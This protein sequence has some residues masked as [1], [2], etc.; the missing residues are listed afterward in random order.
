MCFKLPAKKFNGKPFCLLCMSTPTKKK[1]LLL[2]MADE[3]ICLISVE[4][5]KFTVTPEAKTILS[6]IPG[7]VGVISIAG[8]YRTGKSYILNQL[9]G[10]NDGFEIGPTIRPCT[11]GNTSAFLNSLTNPLKTL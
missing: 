8:L 7:P 9:I 3:P 4:N 1:K 5:G 11:K 2:R 6:Q 10:R